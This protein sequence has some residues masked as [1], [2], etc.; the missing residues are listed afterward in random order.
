M[1]VVT[2]I[3][4]EVDGLRRQ[5]EERLTEWESLRDRRDEVAEDRR[6]TEDAVAE[7]QALETEIAPLC[8]ECLAI[9]ERLDTAEDLLRRIDALKRE[10]GEIS[11]EVEALRDRKT[12]LEDAGQRVARFATRAQELE[13]ANARLEDRQAAQESELGALAARA[14]TERGGLASAQ[15]EH[16]QVNAEVSALIKRRVEPEVNWTRSRKPAVHVT[17]VWRI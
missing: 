17:P 16:G 14:A 8:A 3:E 5:K 15:T 11:A 9:R 7:R 2:D 12:E 10:H 1:A 6:E 13:T 4:A